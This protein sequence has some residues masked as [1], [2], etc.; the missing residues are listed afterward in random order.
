MLLARMA[1]RQQLRGDSKDAAARLLVDAS[2]K[3]S[4]AKDPSLAAVDKE[5]PALLEC[6]VVMV[7]A[8][9]GSGLWR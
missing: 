7:R 1:V 3:D 9:N 5:T 6:R 4:L 2:G 8:P